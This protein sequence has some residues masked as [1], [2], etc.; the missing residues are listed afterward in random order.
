MSYAPEL[1]WRLAANEF[2][3]QWED[4]CRLPAADQN[5][6]IAAYRVKHQMEAVSSYAQSKAAEEK[7]KRKKK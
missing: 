3:Y 7:A 5:S 6:V 2:L 4:F 1:E